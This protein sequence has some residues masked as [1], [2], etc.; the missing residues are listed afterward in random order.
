MPL[1]ISAAV[2]AT[3]VRL[4]YL[5]DE[6]GAT[7][8]RVQVFTEPERLGVPVFAA[9]PVLIGGVWVSDVSLPDGEFYTMYDLTDSTGARVDR[10]DS[11]MV[12]DGAIVYAIASLREVRERLNKTTSVDDAELRKMLVA[13]SAE[14]EQ[15]VSRVGTFEV[16]CDGGPVVILPRGTQA[17][18]FAYAD[19]GAAPAV[20]VDLDAGLAYGPFHRGR[21]NVLARVTV[22]APPNHI[23][24]ILAD[25]A[26][27]FAAT[28]RGNAPTALPS[29]YDAAYA[30]PTTPLTLFPRINALA[31][32][33]ASIA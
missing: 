1:V 4:T 9:A 8:S 26:G 7:V 2:N 19:G 20:D 16:R 3:S 32:T 30:E 29:G 17:A 13:A 21:R 25:V 5:P 18:S 31:S 28:Q 24:V 23:E 10:N 6:L 15:K 14:Y 33:F 12:V 11:F 27:Y 22:P